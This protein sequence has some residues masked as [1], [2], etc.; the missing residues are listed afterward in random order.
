MHRL[1]GGSVEPRVAPQAMAGATWT[2]RNN[3]SICM[4]LSYVYAAVVVAWRYQ[5]A[6]AIVVRARSQTTVDE[7][8]WLVR[9]A[10]SLTT[11]GRNSFEV[12]NT[13]GSNQG[14]TSM[15]SQHVILLYGGRGQVTSP[16]CN[17]PKPTCHL[18]PCL[19][20]ARAEWAG[21]CCGPVHTLWLA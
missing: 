21:V 16:T 7:Q 15:T 3:C 8:V 4:R 20:E 13:W 6:G 18:N 5:A 1:A 12:R 19:S 9:L 17:I 2:E 11:G 10:C 14:G